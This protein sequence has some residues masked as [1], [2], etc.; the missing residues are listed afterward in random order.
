VNGKLSFPLKRILQYLLG[1]CSFIFARDLAI[2]FVTELEPRYRA[3]M[4]RLRSV[5]DKHVGERCFIIGNGPSLKKTDLSKLKDEWTFGMNR[6]YLLFKQMGFATT[7]YVSINRLVIEQCTQEILNRVPCPKFINWRA[8]DLIDFST[9]MVFV[10]PRSGGPR[11]YTDLTEGVWQGATVTYVAMQLAY[12]M[13]FHKVIL[14]G[15]DHSFASKGRPYETIVADGDDQN[16]FD[17][18]YFGRGFKWQ[19][20]DLATSELAYIIAKYKFEESGREIV[21]ATIGGRLEVFRKVAYQSLF[22]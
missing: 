5:R 7:Y 21:D 1:D 17:P 22:A 4:R 6:I 13:G 8:R 2:Q 3:S 16:H 10:H 19:L 18:N 11:F 14:I 20:P 12:Y 15:V 9:D